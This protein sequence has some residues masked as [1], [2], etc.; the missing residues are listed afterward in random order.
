METLVNAHDQQDDPR[1]E[2]LRPG[3]GVRSCH[4]RAPPAKGKSNANKVICRTIQESGSR[5]NKTRA[6]HT[7]AEW[8][9]L[10][11]QTRENVQR[12]QDARPAHLSQ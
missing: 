6:C 11:R 9:E 12:I 2:R 3:R 8:A 7:Q 4:D 10:R 5:L 1:P